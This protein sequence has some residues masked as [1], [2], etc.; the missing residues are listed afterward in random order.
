MKKLPVTVLSGFLGAGKTTLLNH[1]LH[2]KQGLKV[3]VIV[4]DMSEVNI[5]TQLIQN[6]NSLSRT[7]E[8]LVEMSNGCICCT[9]RED[10]MIE[11]EKLAKEN[12]F[13]YLIIESTGISEPIPV[14]QTF[15]FA[16][17]DGSID[18]SRFS[19]VDTMVTVVDAY[20][21]LKDFSSAQYL[22]DRQLTNIENDD[23]T[24]VNLLTDQ[25]EFANV[26]LLNKVDLVTK[27]E[28]KNVYDI[29]QKLNPGTRIFP[30]KNSQI[31]LQ[32]IINTGLFNFE[33]AENSAGWIR[34]LE[35]EHVPETEEYGIGSFV[36]RNKKPFHPER[37]LDYVSNHFPSNIIRSKGLFWLASRSNQALIWSTA[38]GSTKIDPAGVWWASMSFAE[39]ISYPSFLDNQKLIESD[40]IN[41]FGDRKIELVFIGQHLDVT[42][43]TLQ[44]EKCLL[45]NEEV[46]DWKTGEFSNI[47]NWPIPSYQ[48]SNI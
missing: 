14:A 15:S 32:E 18:L 36:F 26:I 9:L 3:A 33:E 48:D 8:C 41:P 17:E 40:W 37:F 34:E 20:N 43:I 5:D 22:S 16:S 23:R 24:I 21:F 12:R 35:N 38:G 10:L 39:R 2:N 25:I 19:Y 11:V 1:I 28:L 7:E 31:A 46:L 45:T 30:T 44:L 13:D 27:Q 4:N 47:D 42:T 29:L 6:E